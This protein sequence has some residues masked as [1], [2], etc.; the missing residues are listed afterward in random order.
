MFSFTQYQL[1][2]LSLAAFIYA[3]ETLDPHTKMVFFTEFSDLPHHFRFMMGI[4]AGLV[5]P[6]V[7]QK[8]C[9]RIIHGEEIGVAEIAF[10]SADIGNCVAGNHFL[11]VPACGTILPCIININ[12][13]AYKASNQ[14]D[15]IP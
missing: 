9:F 2:T 1:F 7:Y 8:D 13:Q 6:L 12:C 15:D 10:L 14:P 4:Q 3:V 11:S 5:F